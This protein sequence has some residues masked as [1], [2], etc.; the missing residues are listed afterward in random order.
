MT[1]DRHCVRRTTS[2]CTLALLL[3]PVGLAAQADSV[4]KVDLVTNSLDAMPP[5]DQAFRLRVEMPKGADS[6]Y[7]RYGQACDI[8]ARTGARICKP[9]EP[10]IRRKGGLIEATAVD[11]LLDE[12]PP[13]RPYLFQFTVY[14]TTAVRETDPAKASAGTRD[15]VIGERVAGPD[16]K[17]DTTRYIRPIKDHATKDSVVVET[18][19]IFVETHA[20]F[21]NHFDTDF[22]VF[23]T[24]HNPGPGYIGAGTNVHFYLSAV[25]KKERGFRRT[26]LRDQLFKRVSLFAGLSFVTLQAKEEVKNRYDVG[27]PLFGLGI[28]PRFRGRGEYWNFFGLNAGLVYFQQDAANPLVTDGKIK[29]APFVSI[30]G[31]I[32]LKELLGPLATLLGVKG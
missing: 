26:S 28:K 9:P 11:F 13:N 19:N 7:F 16:M 32:T 15:T 17:R 29:H 18:R 6:I 27:N 24:H 30:T 4:I 3:L 2:L 8:G 12:I 31:D 20:D 14:G 22:G 21:A 25:N 1:L 23:M 10:E 5:F